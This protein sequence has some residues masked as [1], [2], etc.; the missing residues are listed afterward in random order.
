MEL[1]EAAAVAQQAMEIYGLR[2]W[3]FKFDNAKRRFGCC[4][5]R[6]Q[7]ISLSRY[8]TELNS[9]DNVIDTVLHEV[10]HALAG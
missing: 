10:A 2:G 9:R 6:T 1:A 4:N 7:T 8:V 3:R 5:Y